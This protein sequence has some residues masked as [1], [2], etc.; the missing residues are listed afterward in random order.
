MATIELKCQVCG[1]TD[2]I[3]RNKLFK[4]LKVC[5]IE[6]SNLN[7]YTTTNAL[8]EYISS[9]D[10][11]FLYV[12]GGRLRGK[13]LQTC[14]KYSFKKQLW[15]FCPSMIENRGSHGAISIDSTKDI[16][17]I[18]GGGIKSNLSTCEKLNFETQKW[19]LIANMNTFRHAL[20]VVTDSNRYIYAIAG[21]YDGSKS[22]DQIERYD[23]NLNIWEILPCSMLQS[24]R[25]AGGCFS[26]Y[27]NKIYIFGGII[28]D[29]KWFTTTAEVYDIELN[30]WHEIKEI[31]IA[32]ACSAV[33]IDNQP[34]IYVFIHGNYVTSYNILTN[35]YIQ[36]ANLPIKD[37]F[38]FEVIYLPNTSFII[39]IGGVSNG[40]W[41]RVIYLYDTKNNNWLE[42]PSM[43]RQ[44]RRCAA[45]SI[46]MNK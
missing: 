2:F 33:A 14:E 23:I 11:I 35:S 4:H 16:F 45:T 39:C 19:E 31:P 41:L 24:R 22:S 28:D 17:L 29:I 26:N 13:T 40:N 3:S 36:L 25:L 18:G 27:N 15:E 10:D 44:R 32:N 38:N 34:L 20:T 5:N 1:N 8:E 21:W 12:L 42:L 43:I 30:T 46:V 9:H 6:P 7:E 37:W